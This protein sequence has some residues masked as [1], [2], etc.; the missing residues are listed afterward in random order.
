M[1]F[2]FA[3]SLIPLHSFD[4]ELSKIPPPPP[5]HFFGRDEFVEQAV[6]TLTSALPTQ[7]AILGG[8]GIGKTSGGLAILHHPQIRELFKDNWYFVP[9]DG[10]TSSSILMHNILRVLGVQTREDDD[11]LAMMHNRLA[12][13]GPVLLILDN[14]ETPWESSSQTAVENILSRIANINHVGLI[15]TMRGS[16]APVQIQ[17]SWSL[18][19][20]EAGA[21]FA[22]FLAIN[23]ISLDD[24]SEK[25]LATLLKEMDHVPL[26]ITLV[27]QLSRGMS[28]Q[29]MLKRWND[30]HT[31][32]LQTNQPGGRLTSVDISITVSL[33][34]VLVLQNPEA[35]ELLSLLSCLP[36]G[37]LNWE[38][39][40]ESIAGK[41]NKVNHAAAILLQVGLVY[42]GSSDALKVL[43]PIRHHMM[44]KHPAKPGHVQQLEQHYINMISN[45]AQVEYG[46]RW[47]E[48]KTI[49]LPEV[50]NINAVLRH[51]ILDHPYKEVAVA[52]YNQSEFLLRT[53][54]ST[55]LLGLLLANNE[56]LEWTRLEPNIHKLKGK[57][58]RMVHEYE[59]A[60]LELKLGQDMFLEIED[61]LGAAQCLQ[62]LGNICY[63]QAKYRVAQTMLENAQTQFQN[64]GDQLGVA[65]CLKYLGNICYIQGKYQEAQTIL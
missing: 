64:I 33:Q 19:P 62:S 54:P 18:G 32:L 12:S 65:Q 60:E 17:W 24:E 50:G 52:A 26:A 20:L 61:Q 45:H 16:Q 27:A 5:K 11:V 49:M 47:I 43:S 41:I 8:G 6:Q 7:I 13:L 55:E 48:A 4:M 37:L 40:L 28:C 31:A 34:S 3:K 57:M 59:E 22:A 36:D 63:L 39:N 58:H 2:N 42:L 14:F 1:C 38:A 15:I 35:V 53:Q 29:H 30:E 21:A 51:A 9:C 10:A 25:D 23:P 44:T 46:P 56:I